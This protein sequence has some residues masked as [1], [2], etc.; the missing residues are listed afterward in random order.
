MS[1]RILRR[2][3][4]MDLTGLSRSGIYSLIE[5]GQFP[6]QIKLGEKAVGWPEPEVEAWIE[7]RIKASREAQ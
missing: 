3:Q 5:R 1:T 7:E 2:R 6:K 4:V